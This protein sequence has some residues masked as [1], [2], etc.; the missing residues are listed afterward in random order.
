MA[1]DWSKYPLPFEEERQRVLK[2]RP[3]R[4]SP[5]EE[6]NGRIVVLKPKF[7]HPLLQRYLLP[8]LKNPMY[9]VHL[10]EI[11]SFV[12]RLCDGGHSVGDIE[13]ELK[14][15]FGAAVEPAF[16]RLTLFLAQLFRGRF[17]R[18]VGRE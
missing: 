1:R 8:R 13:Q 9:R 12:W 7:Q 2:L 10:D 16:E 5:W 6:V 18:Y 4:I 11:G 14:K 17:I 15:H 3:L